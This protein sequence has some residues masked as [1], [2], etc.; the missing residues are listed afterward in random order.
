MRCIDK[1]HSMKMNSVTDFLLPTGTDNVALLYLY[2]SDSIIVLA[3]QFD[4]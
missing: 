4:N 3:W 2:Y 1:K